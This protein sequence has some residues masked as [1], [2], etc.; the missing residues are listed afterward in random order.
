MPLLGI[1][2]EFGLLPAMVSPWMDNNSLTTYL[3]HNFTALTIKSKLQILQQVA[4]GVSYLHSKDVVHGDLTA[5]N[6]LIDSNCNVRVADHGILIMCSELSGT[7]NIRSNV[8]WAAPEIFKLPENGQ[9]LTPVK[10]PSDVYSLGCI[11]LQ[12]MTGW[13]PYANV[14]SHYQVIGLILN[15]TKPTRPF[16]PRIVDSLWD[17]IEECWSDAACRPSAAEVLSFLRSYDKSRHRTSVRNL[18]R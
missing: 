1:G 3:K 18:W 7:S 15:G 10:P 12:V 9:S 16:S 11:I 17:F 2:Y 14:R 6:I 5:N 4:A 8:R 13:P